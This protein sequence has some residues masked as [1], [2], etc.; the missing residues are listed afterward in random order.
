MQLKDKRALITGAGSGIGRELAIEAARRGLHVAIVGRRLDALHDTI[1]RMPGNRHRLPL[2][3]DITDPQIR[4]ALRDYLWKAWGGLD[5]L[6]NNAGVVNVGPFSRTTDADLE[7]MFTTNLIAPAALTRELLPLLIRARPSRVV[8][9]GSVFG[10]ISYPLFAAYS[11][12]KFGLRG[13]S[14][15]LRRELRQVQVGITYAAPRATK[16]NAASEFDHLVE[17]LQMKLDEPAKVA[18]NI[19][20]AVARDADT[21]YV[22]GPERFF[23]LVERLF[24]SLVDRSIDRQLHDPKLPLVFKSSLEGRQ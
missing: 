16:T 24:P 2:D 19:W 15:A 3:G 23:V 20:D 12:T 4:I 14:N 22:R 8:N 5:V 7:R 17:P 11:A 10:D 18:V 6:I 21:A 9:V 13:L 1:S